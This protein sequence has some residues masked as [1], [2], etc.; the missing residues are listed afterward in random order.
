MNI[1]IKIYLTLLCLLLSSFC[2]LRSQVT[3]GSG[4][5]PSAGALLDLKQNN[6]SGA[7]SIGGLAMPRVELSATE[8]KNPADLAKSIGNNSGSYDLADHVG[9]VIYNIKADHCASKPINKGMYVWN[10]SQWQYLG[11]AA[12]VSADVYLYTD[13][14]DGEEY[15]YRAFGDPSAPDF[16]GYWMLENLR[17]DPI[18]HEDVPGGFDK[19]T[20]THTATYNTAP[21][22]DKYFAYAEGNKISYTPGNHPSVNWDKYKKNGILYNWGAATNGRATIGNPQEGQGDA[23]EANAVGIQGICPSGWHLPS[24][25]EWNLLEKELYN[26]A[27]KYSQYKNDGSDAFSPAT[28]QSAPGSGNWEEYVNGTNGAAYY[29]RGSTNGKGHGLAMLSECP[30]YNTIVTSGGKSLSAAQGGFEALLVGYASSGSIEAYGSYSCF[31]SSSAYFSSNAWFRSMF[32]ENPKLSR[33][34]S[35]RYA[36]SSV[37]CKKDN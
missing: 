18:L 16:A 5:P 20:F 35:P 15:H 24:D 29:Y 17:Y 21:Y 12:P 23:D 7:N 32:H 26:H 30:P 27:D 2:S 31:W 4:I 1:R 9:L 22:T 6:N 36:L 37:R 8:P 13:P 33:N 28:W 10:G 34:Y 14:R 3:I 19:T 11:Q 25:R